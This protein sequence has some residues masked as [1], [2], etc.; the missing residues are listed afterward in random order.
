MLPGLSGAAG[1]QPRVAMTADAVGG[2]WTYAL[3]LAAGLGQAAVSTILIVAGPAPSDAQRR[4][5]EAVEGLSVIEIDAPLDWTAADARELAR[6]AE[7]V[8]D[9]AAAAGADVVHLNGPALAAYAEFE[10]PVLGACHSCL[11]TWW[12]TVKHG[13]PP[14]AFDW[15]I[16]AAA[17]G[18]A[19]CSALVA[20]TRAFAEATAEVY[21][22]AKPLVVHNGRRPAG[23]AVG[24][25][26]R[27]VL[28]AGRLW[29]DGKDVRTLDRA[30]AR[31]FGRFVA[32][33][34][35]QA[36][37]GTAMRFDT[38]RTIGAVGADRVAAWMARAQVFA[39]AALYEP[40]GLAVLEAAQAGLPLVL[41]DIPSFRELWSGAAVFVPPGDAKGFA[42]AIEAMLD[43][44][45]LQAGAGLAARLRAERYGVGAM[46]N[47]YL[48]AYARLVPGVFPL[49]DTT[50]IL[51]LC[52]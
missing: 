47:G 6:A 38:L 33:G 19:A 27:L 45:S 24:A 28:T 18:Y 36:P 20:P 21:G 13:R 11:A 35:T 4:Q 1:R 46:T 12:R 10:A 9:I 7:T 41:S 17:A 25:T 52:S 23:A 43:S 16:R 48:S 29:D 51:E 26:E 42:D 50:R 31:V 15:R 3:D 40:F 32:L 30:A 37:D 49:S 34:P 2:V 44:P 5:A 39:S 8:A 22:I 14:E